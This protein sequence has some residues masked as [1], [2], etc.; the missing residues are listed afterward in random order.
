MK[1]SKRTEVPPQNPSISDEKASKTKGE[2]IKQYFPVVFM[3]LCTI[4]AIVFF[5][6]NRDFSFERFF[7]STRQNPFIC[8]A[9][10]IA[11]F[12]IKGFIAIVPYS[13]IVIS[14]MLVMNFTEGLITVCI[15]TLICIAV[16]YW[17][18]RSAKDDWI[19]KILQKHP[20]MRKYYETC[21]DNL[22]M[23][24]FVMRVFNLSN[25]ALGL[26]FGSAGL[27]FFPYLIGSFIAI[28]PSGFLYVVIGNSFDLRSPFVW[29]AVAADI[30]LISVTYCIFRLKRKK[31][32]LRK[33]EKNNDRL[34]E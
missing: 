24:S 8:S 3:G 16:P 7:E 5:A 4:A 28:L 1:R 20:K 33:N 27:A 32:N 18:G 13:V 22:F 30:V 6:V 17:I 11:I 21:Y 10:V 29:I 26:F 15:G 34:S 9:V 23:M 12:I 14:S 2:I 25:E 19:V 31:M